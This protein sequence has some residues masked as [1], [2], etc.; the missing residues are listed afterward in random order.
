VL[1]QHL[2]LQAH[3]QR[4]EAAEVVVQVIHSRPA[5]VAQVVAVL[6]AT[7]ALDLTQLITLAAVEAALAKIQPQATE[8]LA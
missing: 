2:Q 7:R 4:A 3:R 1:E 6:V 8:A 5:T